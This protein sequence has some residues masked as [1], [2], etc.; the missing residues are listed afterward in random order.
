MN[1]SPAGSLLDES[2]LSRLV[3]PLTDRHFVVALGAALPVWIALGLGVGGPLHRPVG[4]IAWLAFVPWQPLLEE[5]VFRG[6]LQGRLLR[7]LGGRPVTH[8]RAFA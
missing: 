2:G 7:I 6:I 1:R 8:V 5:V 4:L 3:M